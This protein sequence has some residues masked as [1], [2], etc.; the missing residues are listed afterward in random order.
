MTET[1]GTTDA[2]AQWLGETQEARGDET[3]ERAMDARLSAVDDGSRSSASDEESSTT[4]RSTHSDASQSTPN[5]SNRV[6]LAEQGGASNQRRTAVAWGN[7]EDDAFAAQM[8]YV[9]LP[10]LE[11]AD[12]D[13]LLDTEAADDG[14]ASLASDSLASDN[15]SESESDVSMSEADQSSDDGSHTSR[16]SLV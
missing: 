13:W 2:I 10:D 15:V 14:D 16:H 6:N 1:S 8:D 5:A 7:D 12:D 4:S 3:R 9:P 11:A